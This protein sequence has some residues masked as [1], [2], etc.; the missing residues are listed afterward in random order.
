ML[1]T[2]KK[3]FNSNSTDNKDE[4]N[5]KFSATAAEI[6][7]MADNN[8]SSDEQAVIIS[9]ELNDSRDL[10]SLFELENQ[11]ITAI[12]NNSA[13]EYDGNEISESGNEGTLYIYGK[14][15]DKIFSVVKPLF[16]KA[17]FIKNSNALLRYGP[18]EDGIKETKIII[19]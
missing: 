11:I 5:Y 15:A 6:I 14:D 2:L 16:E 18:P 13:G 12:N 17:A 8:E 19:G 4:S 9:F 10:K 7:A 1:N 3:M